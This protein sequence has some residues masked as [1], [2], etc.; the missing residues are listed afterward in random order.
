MPAPQNRLAIG[1]EI[2]GQDV[3]TLQRRPSRIGLPRRVG[4][5]ML[6]GEA[7][8][9]GHAVEGHRHVAADDDEVLDGGIAV[10][11]ARYDLIPDRL[12]HRVSALWIAGRGVPRSVLRRDVGVVIDRDDDAAHVGVLGERGE[13]GQQIRYRSRAIHS[14]QALFVQEYQGVRVS[15]WAGRRPTFTSRIAEAARAGGLT[16][17][18]DLDAQV[19]WRGTPVAVVA[20][21]DDVV[22]AGDAGVGSALFWIKP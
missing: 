16:D 15:R 19:I 18:H 6:V 3:A 12:R 21:D 1:V 7:R 2:V 20:V 9:I 11:I 5:G 14:V 22:V 10:K 17:R 4:V 8:L 13:V